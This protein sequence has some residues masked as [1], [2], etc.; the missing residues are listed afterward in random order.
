MINPFLFA[1]H[2]RIP[3]IAAEFPKWLGNDFRSAL[4]DAAKS[5]DKL[6]ILN[7]APRVFGVPIVFNLPAVLI[8]VAITAVLV[9]GIKESARFNTVMVCI[10]LVVLTFFVIVGACYVRPENYHPFM[11]NGWAGVQA[12]AAAVF[13]AY[14]GFDAVSTAA[15]ECRNPRR[16]LPIGILGSLGIC[17]VIYIVVGI[18]LTGMSKYSNFRGV[19]EPLSVAMRSVKLGW[20]AG[21]ISLGSVIAHT[22]VLLVFQLGQPRILYAMSRDGLLPKFFGKTH[23]RFRTPHVATILTGIFV[24]VPSAFCSLEEMADLCSI[25][26][27]SA[28]IIVCAGII[29]LRRRDPDRSTGFRT[30][31]VPLIPILGIL[32]CLWLVVGLGWLAWVRFVAWLAVGLVLYFCYGFWTPRRESVPPTSPPVPG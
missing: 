25:G 26:T 5:E 6:G 18:V 12:G 17:T 28:F 31:W 8:V 30:P 23:P 27:L 1:I 24:A 13:F 29:V 4:I 22:A 14:I 32:S 7:S 20:A 15:E 19:A 16:D 2:K 10:K 9:I 11:P 3:W 21:I